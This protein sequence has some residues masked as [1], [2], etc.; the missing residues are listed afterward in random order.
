MKNTKPLTINKKKSQPICHA[1]GTA[2]T[3]AK[4]DGVTTRVPARITGDG[5][6]TFYGRMR[7]P[8]CAMLE[9]GIT[10][11]MIVRE[12]GL[13]RCCSCSHS[14]RVLNAHAVSEI[15]REWAQWQMF[16]CES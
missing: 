3:F 14:R 2:G 7:C 9:L 13:W 1:G 8:K 11:E 5:G 15:H 16:P 12:D 10:L 4:E 6:G